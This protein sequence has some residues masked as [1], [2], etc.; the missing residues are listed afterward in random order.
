[1]SRAAGFFGERVP[2]SGPTPHE[3]ARTGA[4]D[5]GNRFPTFPLAQPTLRVKRPRMVARAVSF[6][7]GGIF[8]IEG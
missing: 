6:F 4:A 7:G 5:L 8:F 1:V 3:G 2:C